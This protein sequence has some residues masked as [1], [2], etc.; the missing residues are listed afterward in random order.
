VYA[1]GHGVLAPGGRLIAA[2]LA[3]GEVAVLS[4]R[5][6]AAWWGLLPSAASRVDVTTEAGRHRATGI[7]HHRARSLDAREITTHDD[8]PITTVARTLLDLAATVRGDRLERALAQAERLQLYDHAAI[9]DV[10]AR[11]NGHR[12]RGALA[13]ATGRAPKWTRSKLEAQLLTLV[14]EAGLPEPLVNEDVDAP[15]R[16]PC[17]ADFHWPA[18]RV[19]VETDGYETHGTRAAFRDDRRRDAALQAV[20]WRVVRFAWEDVAYDPATVRRRL[21]SMLRR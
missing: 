14:R 10:L 13:A 4:H 16:G 9:T 18:H 1:V 15:D 8:M 20:G 19:I 12:G 21:E 2:I 3:C 17:E 5:S 7:R 6:A 11:S